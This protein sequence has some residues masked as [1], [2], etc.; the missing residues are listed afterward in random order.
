[1]RGAASNYDPQVEIDQRAIRFRYKSAFGIYV[2][3]KFPHCSHPIDQRQFY[4]RNCNHLECVGFDW[5][6]WE[7]LRYQVK[8][9]QVEIY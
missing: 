7:V 8:S 1:M 3:F 2:S 5:C 6:L 9:S 4:E